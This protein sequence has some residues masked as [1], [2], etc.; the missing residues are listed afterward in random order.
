MNIYMKFP[1][2]ESIL[3]NVHVK[4]LVE[5]IIVNA[6]LRYPNQEK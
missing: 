5:M 4:L 2:L 3:D 6:L 1:L